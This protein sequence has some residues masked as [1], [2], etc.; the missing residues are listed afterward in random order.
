MRLL[1]PVA[2]LLVASTPVFAQAPKITPQ[3]DPS[4]RNDT[5]YS[6]AVDP[7]QF[8]EET[9]VFL[10]DDGVLRMEAD[11]RGTRTF[12]YV[13]QI[14]REDAVKNWREQRF[15]FIPERQKLTINWV[16]VL[17][18]DGTVISAEPSLVQ[19]SDVPASMSSPVYTERRV[20]RA[21]LSGV[22]VNTIVDYS[23]TIEELDPYH[24]GDFHQWW[25]VTTGLQVRRSRLILDVPAGLEPRVVERNLNFPRKTEVRNG[26]RVMTWATGDLPRVKGEPFAAD[27]NDI[28][29]A[30]EISAPK[31]WSDVSRW[32][33]G[34]AN[35]RYPLSPEVAAKVAEVVADAR[36]AED[37]LRAVHRWVAQDIRYVS[38]SLGLGGY[39]P[40]QTG[41]VLA[42]G[43]GDCKDKSTLFIGALR[44]LG[45]EAHPVLVNSRGG[46][47]PQ[48][49]SI[50]Q[51]NHLIAVVQTDTGSVYTDLTHELMP[52]G[53][54]PYAL[55]GEFG[56]VV[57]A[58]GSAREVTMPRD[59]VERNVS[60]MR[61]V[62][63]IDVSG[64]F[65]G[66]Y[67]EYGRGIH[68][69]GLRELF[70]TPFDSTQAD[71]FARGMASN[72]FDGA[73]GDSLVA[74]NGKDLQ[75]EPRLRVRIRDGR[76]VSSSGNTAILTFPI[77]GMGGMISAAEDLAAREPRRF[78]LD[79]E[80][81]IGP[82][83]GLSEI[84]IRLP[85]G[86]RA[87]V[88]PSVSASSAFGSY[89][90]V[91]RQEGNE[92]KLTRRLSG[93]IGI[94]PATAIDELIAW[95]REMGQ[96]DVRFIL[97][98]KNAAE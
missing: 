59:P 50:H 80:Q 41:E 28:T 12:R 74:F 52:F 24:P 73:V 83:V 32:Y 49:P 13:G 8:P 10:L 75:A 63:A 17:R 26:R 29:M 30:I 56:V 53:E 47:T 57:L 87:R 38:V 40:R 69:P 93:T 9:A 89:S 18:P 81:V 7:A 36:T 71:Q 46:V 15:S 42:T 68:A 31:E 39:Q 19:E 3:G 62:G 33:A 23:Y 86:W 90:S 48:L 61:L 25:S 95:Y 45:F 20:I 4:V 27:T 67:E 98:D 21:S 37:T 1:L 76:A 60:S 14:L 79:A 2:A 91:Y 11:G 66:V 35:D 70:S 97:I 64:R 96:D 44:H 43:F 65:T 82:T 51:F 55:Q 34:M 54:L 58:D 6:L 77:Q 94:R 88:P 72:F 5:I 85:D 16:R 78:P 92:L 22:A 84:S